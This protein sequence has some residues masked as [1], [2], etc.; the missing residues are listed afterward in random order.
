MRVIQLLPTIAYGD[1]IGNHV[2]AL[3]KVIENWGFET[4][5]WAENLDERLSSD[6]AERMDR[7]PRLTSQDVII[8]HGSGG[9]ALNTLL[10]T[11]PGRKVM[12]Y[13]N[14]TPPEWFHGYSEQT[15]AMTANGQREIR[16]L[17]G[18]LDYCLAVSEYNKR[19][20]LDMGYNCPVDV[21][22]ILISFD[23]YCRAPSMEVLRR[24]ADG[25]TKI[26]FVGRVSPNKKHEDV[27]RAFYAYHKEFNSQSRLYL[28]G[29]QMDTYFRRL[30]RYAQTL[31]IE[32]DVI[33]TG[34]IP[35]EELLAYYQMA[36]VFLCMSEHEGFCVPLVEAMYFGVPVVAYASTAIPETLGIGG[37]L[38]RDKSPGQAA[39]EI[40]RLT[41]DPRL[42]R[43][44]IDRQRRRLVDFYPENIMAILERTLLRF[45][46]G[47]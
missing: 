27:I 17:A 29:G 5:I 22:P 9:S 15:E 3:R 16:A 20:L 31:K 4:G 37:V 39:R 25:K 23:E 46:K 18:K 38:L 35:T 26:L 7:F 36:D 47:E 30:R 21:C 40:Y 33:F 10:P 8:Y 32:E 1:A 34:H 13:H 24:N 41:T 42:R 45:I 44:V 19:G 43:T 11:L 14:I 6:T 2:L 12:I 28:I